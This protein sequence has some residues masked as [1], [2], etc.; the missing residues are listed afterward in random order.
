M[1]R[2]AFVG[3]R[4]RPGLFSSKQWG[5]RVS[6]IS[7]AAERRA[8]GEAIYRRRGRATALREPGVGLGGTLYA[9][10]AAG[11]GRAHPPEAD[12]PLSRPANGRPG[13]AAGRACPDSIDGACPRKSA[14]ASLIPHEDCASPYQAA[15]STAD[16]PHASTRDEAIEQGRVSALLGCEADDLCSALAHCFV[17]LCCVGEGPATRFLSLQGQGRPDQP[18][19]RLCVRL[20]LRRLKPPA[21]RQLH[22]THA[23]ATPQLDIKK[24]ASPSNRSRSRDS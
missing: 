16:R 15:V 9:C 11:H 7:C 22:A 10:P 6:L 21:A 8:V 13:S 5:A 3:C 24:G 2:W 23:L 20:F 19:A 1:S 18:H 4:W 12:G 17:S 14:A